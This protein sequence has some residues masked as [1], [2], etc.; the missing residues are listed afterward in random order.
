MINK[1]VHTRASS[2][3]ATSALY[4]YLELLILIMCTNWMGTEIE[5]YDLR[6]NS[7]HSGRV[8]H[9]VPKLRVKSQL[10]TEQRGF[11]D[12]NLKLQ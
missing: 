10:N 3:A 11:K 8:G 2:Y 1:V 5:A 12:P 4:K 6:N 7:G 9:G